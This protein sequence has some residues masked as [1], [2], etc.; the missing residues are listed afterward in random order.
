MNTVFDT[1]NIA[2]YG[3]AVKMDISKVRYTLR[4]TKKALRDK[5]YRN[6]ARYYDAYKTCA[7]DD[8]MIM[9]EAFFGRAITCN[10][11][12]LFN[13]ILN[14]ERFK[15]YTHV[16]SLEKSEFRSLIVEKYKNYPNVIFVEPA[17]KEYFRYLSTAKYLI[18]NVT[19][20]AYFTKKDE[21][22]V[23]NTWHGIPLKSL[24][25]DIPDGKTNVSNIIRNMLFTD[26]LISPV[27]YTTENFKKAFKLEGIFPGK[28]IETGYPRTDM[29]YN[30]DKDALEK[31]LKKY[32]VRY[33]KTKKL[34][35][36]APTWKGEQY[37]NPNIDTAEY[38]RFIQAVE[39]AV[40]LN[41]YQVLFKPHQIV[42]KSL[43]AAGKLKDF[44]IPAT[45]DTNTLLGATDVLISDYSSIFFDF[46]I[47]DKPILFYV[48][49]LAD[50]AETRGLY[51][52]V[53]DLP[54]PTTD[55]L[56]QLAE[57]CKNINDYKSLF[58][59]SKYENAKKRFVTY[60]D[61]NVCQRVV[62]AVFF[63]KTDHLIDIEAKTKK[64]LLFHTDKIL[65][66]GISSSMFSL[67]NHIDT[68]KYD[69][70]F[71][72]IGPKN[73]FTMNY[74]DGINDDIRVIY[75]SSAMNVNIKDDVKKE[76]CLD[77]AIVSKDDGD[78]ADV[79]YSAEYKR[80][81]GDARFDYIINFSGFS[82]Y[83]ANVYKSQ[84][85][86][87][88][89]IWMHS[90]LASEYN[91]NVNGKLIFKRNLDNI[92]K[93]YKYLDK[94][95]SCSKITM[96]LNKELLLNDTN[97]DKFAYMFN[98]IDYNKINKGVEEYQT[99]ELNSKEYSVAMRDDFNIAVVPTPDK[100]CKVLATVGRLSPE[101][102]QI[103]LIKA[104]ARINKEN[105]DTQLYI[106]GDGPSLE[107][108]R[109]CVNECGMDGKIILT[110]NINNPFGLLSKCD[111]FIL[112]SFYEGQ[113]M[114][115]LE[116][117][118]LGIPVIMSNFATVRD[119]S[120]ENGQLIIGMEEDEIYEGLKHFVNGSVPNEYK[121]DPVAYNEKC[122]KEFESCLD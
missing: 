118:T 112:P 36:Y 11:G 85:K 40:D 34:I 80:C 115:L 70:S 93:I 45:V 108:L 98:L 15:D 87:K 106:I 24:G 19:W 86:A 50:Y 58:D 31:E 5:G 1:A 79:Y 68:S 111:C 117:R 21:Q 84:T 73:S 88:N 17:T 27:E 110:G 120:F 100:N 14:D 105:P 56:E 3:K 57:W 83:W 43:V 91:R 4:Y 116:A 122:L 35:M 12:A 59:Y 44:Y 62:D 96:E 61:S 60:D 10:P 46:L 107:E 75:R 66:N 71:Y 52:S 109:E 113:P 99:V 90:V 82:A 92:Y 22:V 49:D 103:S 29:S 25:Y 95:V 97:A 114:V 16:W 94:Y 77:K 101:K 53:E 38:D 7:V 18:N 67:L 13:Y 6:R 9:Y 81:F 69:V 89:I 47:T 55:S 30:V 8:K 63:G 42:Y 48:P 76:Y 64:K 72:A 54:G 23:I 2:V 104:F 119:S 78:F 102:N 33:D 37:A 20:Q 32:G 39:S 74:L 65:A 41:E 28:I 121:F 51:F 26:Y